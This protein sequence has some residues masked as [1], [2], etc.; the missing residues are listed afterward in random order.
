[1]ITDDHVP[2]NEKAHIP[3]IDVIN[4]SPDCQQSSFGPT[5]PTVIDAMQHIDRNTL[6]AVGQ[7]MVQVIYSELQ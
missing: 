6:K 5:C 3:T 1:M 2:L 7:V 4:Y